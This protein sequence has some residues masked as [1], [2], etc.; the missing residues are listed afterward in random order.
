VRL[1][2]EQTSRSEFKKIREEVVFGSFN[3]VFIDSEEERCRGN[4]D[5]ESSDDD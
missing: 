1:G 4:R 5:Y 2:K 3:P